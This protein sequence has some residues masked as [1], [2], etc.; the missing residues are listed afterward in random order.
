MS[1]LK[2]IASNLGR[3]DE[4]PNQEL[5]RDLAARADRQGIAE[6][7]ANLWNPEKR[8]QSDC[9]K[10]LY[11][12][13]SIRADLISDYAED[14]LKLLES[15]N[16]RLVW[17]SMTALSA[18]APLRAELLSRNFAV[19]T[20]TIE[21]GSVITRDHGISVLA[22]LAASPSAARDQAYVYLLKHLRECRSKD[23]PQHSERC[24]PAASG[25]RA[26]GFVE[27]LESRL[28]EL[29]VSQAKRV[30]KAISQARSRAPDRRVPKPESSRPSQ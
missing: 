22:T 3:G 30:R 12:I 7:A 25:Q 16:N 6:I 2:R 26:A 5:A 28:P 23:V 21:N 9:L 18:I 1:V 19:I 17:G 4:V 27:V 24:L 15:R 10:V 20:D 8:I 29:T 13:G 11:E 14:F